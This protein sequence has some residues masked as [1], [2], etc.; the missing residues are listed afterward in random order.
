LNLPGQLVDLKFE[1]RVLLQV[2]C[3]FDAG[4]SLSPTDLAVGWKRISNAAAI[5]QLDISQSVRFFTYR[6]ES[7]PPIP[8]DEIERSAANMT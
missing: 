3:S 1:A 2:D 6:R 7:V 8:L 4:S 5:D